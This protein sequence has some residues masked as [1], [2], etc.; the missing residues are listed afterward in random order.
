MAGEFV[1]FC[2]LMNGRTYTIR[3]LTKELRV[4]A[5]TLRHYEDQKLIFPARRGLTRLYSFEDRARIMIIL[6]GRRLGFTLREMREVLCMYDFKDSKSPAETVVARKKFRER[7]EA[8]E[9]QK[10]DID[11]AL[12][13]LTGCIQEIDG[14]LP[15]A[16]WADFFKKDTIAHL[17][18]AAKAEA[19][20]S[21]K[22]S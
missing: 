1:V 3:E 7:V 9:R 18:Q 4:T 16:P 11:E 20:V 21:A 6:R 10:R 8:L 19:D 2:S 14:V 22:A 17:A 15:R 12:R 5:R 13:Q